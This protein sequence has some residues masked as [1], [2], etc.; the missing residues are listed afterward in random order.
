ML[1]QDSTDIVVKL[2]G[3]RADVADTAGL[4]SWSTSSTEDLLH[5]MRIRSDSFDECPGYGTHLQ[6]VQNRQVHKATL[7]SIIYLRSFDD[8]CM[9]R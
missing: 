4:V 2:I 5:H 1:T 6:D 3:R 7:R 9:C 8:D